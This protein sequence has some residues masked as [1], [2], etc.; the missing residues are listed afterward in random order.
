MS[1]AVIIASL[2]RPAVLAETVQNLR[3]QTMPPEQIILSVTTPQDVAGIARGGDPAAGPVVAVVLGTRGSAVQ[4]NAGLAALDAACELVSFFD[5]DVELA[6]DYCQRMRSAFAANPDVVAFD[7]AIVDDGGRV[8]GLSRDAARALLAAAGPTPA[9]RVDPN[10]SMYGCN[11]NVRRQ[12]MASVQFDEKFAAYGWL[13]DTDFAHRLTAVGRLGHAVDCR[14]VHLA[15]SSGRS[16]GLQMGISQIVNP[17][18]LCRKGGHGGTR[19]VLRRH[20][21]PA[22]GGN[23][24]G[25]L[26]RGPRHIDRWGRLRGNVIGFWHVLRGRADPEVVLRYR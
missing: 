19:H 23:V 11:M 17:L 15:V 20:W 22:V 2:N 3:Q 12:A 9:P 10:R 1:H 5:D 16:S 26:G 18:Y 4:R 13:E 14:L 25:M 6:D 8:G 7:G 24:L 21:I